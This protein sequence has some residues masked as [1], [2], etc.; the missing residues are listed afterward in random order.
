MHLKKKWTH[1][2]T[3]NNEHLV[4]E[5]ALDFLGKLLRFD[6]QERLT[7]EEAMSHPY[8][9]KLF[10]EGCPTAAQSAI[11]AK[12]MPSRTDIAAASIALSAATAA[13]AAAE[14]ADDGSAAV[15]AG[16]A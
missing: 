14:A 16:S 10:A 9:A 12:A 5:E 1:F 6:H 11:G 8:F 3:P 15:D 2:V 13:V 4:S 7:A